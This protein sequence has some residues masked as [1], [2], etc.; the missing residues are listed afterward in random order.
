MYTT[1]LVLRL[2]SFLAVVL[3]DNGSE[4]SVFV[5]RGGTGNFLL[6]L[7]EVLLGRLCWVDV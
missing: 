6:F 2:V 1:E 3:V 7:L 4:G 5:R